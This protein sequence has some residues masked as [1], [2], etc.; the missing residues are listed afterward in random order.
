[1]V[2]YKIVHRLYVHT[3]IH[4]LYIFS[5]GEYTYKYICAGNS[6]T[7]LF[8]TVEAD[9]PQCRRYQA[10]SYWGSGG[11]LEWVG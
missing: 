2:V 1:M 4:V 7:F 10:L 3:N 6:Q 5:H 8:R 11:G 9:G